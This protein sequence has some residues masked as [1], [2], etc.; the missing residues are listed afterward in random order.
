M[1]DRTVFTHICT[2]HSACKLHTDTRASRARCLT[3][4]T[5]IAWYL[6]TRL[7]MHD[8]MHMHDH[9]GESGEETGETPGMNWTGDPCDHGGDGDCRSLSG[10]EASR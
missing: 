9:M 1:M 2:S 10:D 6:A 5:S 4:Y 7:R 3:P 8:R